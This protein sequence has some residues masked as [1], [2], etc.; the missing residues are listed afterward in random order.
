MTYDKGI[1]SEA[2]FHSYNSINILG[3]S[4]IIYFKVSIPRVDYFTI[5][6]NPE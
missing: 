3:V 5:F 6:I 2:N 1:M 4:K